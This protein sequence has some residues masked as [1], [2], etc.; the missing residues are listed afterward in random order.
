VVSTASKPPHRLV[1]HRARASPGQRASAGES[2]LAPTEVPR[3]LASTAEHPPALDLCLRP[4]RSRT[5]PHAFAFVGRPRRSETRT[6]KGRGATDG[7]GRIRS[8]NDEGPRTGP[9]PDLRF[10]MAPYRA[11]GTSDGRSRALA[12]KHRD[13]RRRVL[14]AQRLAGR[15]A[16]DSLICPLSICRHRSRIVR[17]NAVG[18]RIS[19]P[20]G[21][22]SHRGAEGAVGRPQNESTNDLWRQSVSAEA[23]KR[24]APSHRTLVPR[25]VSLSRNIEPP[26]DAEGR[27]ASSDRQLRRCANQGRVYFLMKGQPMLALPGACPVFMVQS[28]IWTPP[29]QLV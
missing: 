12:G 8:K 6:Q 29:P 21:T 2:A 7:W 24:S 5:P 22:T 28:P 13:T 27:L 19:P 26:A 23:S 20:S 25:L 15:G 4:G 14:S 10:P 17:K 11:A 9:A 16:S 3:V 1:C 18:P